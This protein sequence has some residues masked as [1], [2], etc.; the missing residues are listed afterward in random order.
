MDLGLQDKSALLIGGTRGIGRA[1]ARRLAEEGVRLALVAR[2]SGELEATTREIRAAGGEAIAI[3]ADITEPAQAERAVHEA[4]E[5]LGSF[6]ALVHAVG[7]GFPVTFMDMDEA[8]LREAFELD[9]FSAARIVRKALPRMGHGGRIVLLGAASAKQ[10]RLAASASNT[11]KAALSSLVRSLADEL[12]PNGISINC[13]APGRISS[14]RR[15]RRLAVGAQTRGVSLEDA[16]RD[17]AVGIPLGRL[18]EPDEVASVVVFLSSPRASYVT[19][20]SILVDGGLV[21]A[22]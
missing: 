18:G 8:T 2:D 21:R 5:S 16:L 20:Q 9:F 14:E 10:P 4:S 11:A 3:S 15:R 7:R 1:T 19:G 12:A 6:D 13:V 22:V 17:D